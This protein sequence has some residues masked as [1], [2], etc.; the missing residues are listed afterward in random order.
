MISKSFN[1]QMEEAHEM[2]VNDV[3]PNVT[4]Y[5][6]FTNALMK[7]IQYSDEIPRDTKFYALSKLGDLERN[8]MEG[9]NPNVQLVSYLS[10]L[11]VIRYSSIPNYNE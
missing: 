5:S 11:P 9:C 7:K 4:D 3:L 8:I 10:K 2:V 1:G 6:R